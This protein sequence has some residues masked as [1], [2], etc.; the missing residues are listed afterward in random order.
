MY[1]WSV[2]WSRQI[3]PLLAKELKLEARNKFAFGGIMLYVAATVFL[4]YYSMQ[5]QHNARELPAATWNVL[6]WVVIIFAAVNAVAKSFFQ[7]NPG[8]QLYLYTL[9]DPKAIILSKLIFNQIYM[10]LLSGL[11]FL[12]MLLM[13]GNPVQQI[14][15]FT[16]TLVLA[17]SGFAF[18]FTLIS[19]IAS[20]ANNNATLMAVLGF[21]LT[22]PMVVFVSRLAVDCYNPFPSPVFWKTVIMLL[23]LDVILVLLSV[24]LF[25]YLWRD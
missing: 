17:S 22:I 21:P 1:L 12:L 10:L 18:I 7:E 19:S 4:I 14:G 3:F 13:L 2:S 11:A 8:R 5:L 20:K 23:A 9:A 6:F 25:P 15:L 24:I 16:I